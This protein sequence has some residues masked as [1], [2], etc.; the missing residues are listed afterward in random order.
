MLVVLSSSTSARRLKKLLSQKGIAAEIVQTPRYLS[1]GGCSYSL[2]VGNAYLK[3]VTS[4]TA[5]LHIS[6]NKIYR[7]EG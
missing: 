1:D 4:L 7:E 3:E 6:V 2:K 5:R